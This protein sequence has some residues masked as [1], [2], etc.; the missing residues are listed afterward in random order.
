MSILDK[1]TNKIPKYN[2]DMKILS[3]DN[4]S[5]LAFASFLVA[6]SAVIVVWG[7]SGSD[8][9]S[10]KTVALNSIDAKT[11]KLSVDSKVSPQY[12]K[13]IKELNKNNYEA[14]SKSVSGASM[15][16][17]YHTNPDT[18]AGSIEN[19]GCAFDEK[20]KQALIQAMNEELKALGI[21]AIKK[22]DALRLG[23]SDIYVQSNGV[24][25]DEFGATYLWEGKQVK[26]SDTGAILLIESDMPI[27]TTDGQSIYLSNEGKFYNEITSIVRL[28]GRLLSTDGVIV[29][30]SGFKANRPGGM[31]Q[32]DNTDVYIT[33]DTQ[34]ATM[35]GKPVYHSSK[36]VFKDLENRLHNSYSD[37]LS[38]EDKSVYQQDDGAITD[39]A[40][41][42]FSRIGVLIS[43][44]GILID[45]GS[46]LTED[47]NDIKRFGDSDLFV[48]SKNQLVDS[49]GG[50]TSYQ[51]YSV[52][53]GINNS[54]ISEIGP[55]KNSSKS[56][57]YL[58]DTGRF[59]A[60]QPVYLTG[61][62][63]DSLGIAFDRFGHRITRR[64]KLSQL[65]NSVIWHTPDRYLST[66]KGQS[67]NYNN[68]D[69]FQD[70]SRFK[71]INGLDAYGLKI[72][73]GTAIKDLIGRDVYLNSQGHLIYEDGLPVQE[74]GILT[75]SD[76]VVITSQGELV[77]SDGKLKPVMD[78][79]GNQLYYDGKKVF[80]GADGRLYD[81]FGNLLLSKNGIPLR[82]SPDG[83][84]IDE[85]GNVITD[86]L[87]KIMTPIAENS[88]FTIS[89]NGQVFDADGNP[90]Y[91]NG[92]RVFQGKDGLLYD[93]DGNLITDENG[94]PL[95][96]NSDGVIVTPDGKPASTKGF[97]VEKTIGNKNL[98]V[99]SGNSLK[100]LGNS[101]IY[102]TADGL[103][104]DKDGKPITYKGKRVRRGPN[105]QLFDE[106]GQ[107][108]L[109]K[110]GNPVYMNDQGEVV[111]VNG[112]KLEGFHFQN[113]E[114]QYL[115]TGEG[116]P[117]IK[118]IG[119]SDIYSTR[120]GLLTDEQGRP[121]M[122][123]GKPVKIGAG[124]RL[125]TTDGE[126]ITDAKGNSVYLTNGGELKNRENG[127]SKGAALQDSDGVSLDPQGKRVNNGG[128]LTN[129]GN[130]LYRT[131]EGLLVD[132]FGK[133]VLI[134]GKQAFTN[135]EGEIVDANDRA[136]RYQSRRIYLSNTGAILDA[137]GANIT[138]N[139]QALSLTGKGLMRED[140]TLM[141]LPKSQSVVNL[142]PNR[143][144]QR[145]FTEQNADDAI[146]QEAPLEKPKQAEIES[147][148]PKESFSELAKVIDISTLTDEEIVRLN[149]R[150]MSIYQ[151]LDMKLAEYEGEFRKK[152]QSSTAIFT[153]NIKDGIEGN[154]SG[155]TQEL[156][157]TNP[158]Q[159]E[160][161]ILL[162]Q[163]AGTILYAANKMTVNT[164]LET[165]VVFDIMGLPHTHP[166]Y[167]STAHGVV[168]LK[169]DNI[170]IEYNS[171]CPEFDECYPIQGIAV[172]PTT[173]SASINGN[174]NKHYWY[175]FGGLALATLTQGAAVAVGESRD[176]TE[177][178][179]EQGK[180]VTYTGLNGKEL[181]VRSAEPLGTA[182]ANVFMENVNR[183][184]TGTI[185]NGEEVGIFLFEDVVLRENPKK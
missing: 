41:N 46:M 112:N 27:S 132:R 95:S 151:S 59:F 24:L 21:S 23:K 172:D 173:K 62:I 98:K 53:V 118:R 65:G 154:G 63:K 153:Q 5:F 82:L 125:M 93:E 183:P 19:C 60:D 2:P 182:L 150:Y 130:G 48:N 49:Y 169:Y 116:L 110:F 29:L 18:E 73:S 12:Q 166:L 146:T 42:K 161:K 55:V 178:Y 168:T 124:G 122:H 47:L 164:D 31:A 72:P 101:G 133:P 156:P 97:E 40:A 89:E 43:H 179:D 17:V 103:L 22:T 184:Y 155:Y 28:M 119:N 159:K 34:L 104:L 86:K 136:V 147:S 9:A 25:V 99:T 8:D 38:W 30:G 39:R 92:K 129:L 180:V 51:G 131:A 66:E 83:T 128:K 85:D 138:D 120:D 1:M 37:D 160:G 88:G 126:F 6:A 78:E 117:E 170:V 71:I 114:G 4:R 115:E 127:Y 35:D 121:L 77:I 14:A 69:V 45:N 75:T 181:L 61:T 58:Q 26:T 123:D 152:P 13:S 70:I 145:Q 32:V 100:A 113:G 36:F 91:Y 106:Y 90:L 7:L 135:S 80:Q 139:D 107:A 87:L 163:K 54:L 50:L 176:R 141:Q 84:L 3:P 10:K 175:R 81:E 16:I 158:S 96:L 68:Q 171:I 94:Q 109:D 33:S 67:L 167:R 142:T 148:P 165:K 149:A 143:E 144:I 74:A 185:Q 111:D 52:R 56:N 105:G 177:E 134:D 15:P 20:A 76:G 64:G 162:K 44:G 102:Q 174:I 157:P 79:F 57:L 11:D 140:G 137:Q 108:I